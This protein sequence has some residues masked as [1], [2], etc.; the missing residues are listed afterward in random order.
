MPT[1]RSDRVF[2]FSV[3]WKIIRTDAVE[4]YFTDH[5]VPLLLFDG[6][7]Y[8]PAGGIAASANQSQQGLKDNNFEVKGM[9]DSEVIDFED[10]RA[11]KYREAEVIEYV[12]DW[13]NSTAD[14]ITTHRYWIVQTTFN[15]Q[16]W[17]GQIAG[18]SSWIARPVGR[19]YTRECWHDEG[20]SGCMLDLTPITV[21]GTIVTVQKQR[22]SFVSNLTAGID[23]QYND[24]KLVWVTGANASFSGSQVKQYLHDGS[25]SLQLFSAKDFAVGDTFT[26][27][28]TCQQQASK[29]IGLGN[30]I[31]FG[32]F[33]YIPGTDVVVNPPKK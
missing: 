24:S 10:L 6:N 15:G 16:S 1:I 23:G 19:T 33:P 2:K 3:C 22:K 25:L 13:S 20:D 5:D 31:N 9:I 28:S 17:T 4:L 12:V 30:L 27:Y 21:T 18:Q 26:V 32:G 7:V 29:C 11:G 14:P 8:S